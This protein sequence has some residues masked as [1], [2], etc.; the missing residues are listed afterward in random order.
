MTKKKIRKRNILS[1][2]AV[3][4][5]TYFTVATHILNRLTCPPPMHQRQ[6]NRDETGRYGHPIHREVVRI[7]GD[8]MYEENVW[9]SAIVL[10]REPLLRR[11]SFA[12]SCI[13][14]THTLA[15]DHQK[16]IRDSVKDLVDKKT[17]EPRERER[18]NFP[19][20]Q[21]ERR[22]HGQYPTGWSSIPGVVL[23]P[24][25]VRRAWVETYGERP[26]RF[27]QS[28]EPGKQSERSG[29]FVASPRSYDALQQPHSLSAQEKDTRRSG[30]PMLCRYE[31]ISA[32]D[33]HAVVS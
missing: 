5:S 25:R 32:K 19:Y 31:R 15:G 26:T 16:M 2:F 29:S 18:E 23:P 8:E 12:R 27:R 6:R 4:Q 28:T 7:T 1:S 10:V 22:L 3:Q 33:C 13:E 24:M 17:S 11:S 30:A 20:C 14:Y 9:F 21:G